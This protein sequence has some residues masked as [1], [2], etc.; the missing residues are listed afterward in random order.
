MAGDHKV[1]KISIAK[2]MDDIR[3]KELTFPKY[4]TQIINLANQNAQGTRPKI[5]GQMSELI[6][7]CPYNDYV[8]WGEWYVDTMPNAVDEATSRIMGMIENLRKAINEIDEDMVHSWVVDLLITKT[9]VGLKVQ[10]GILQEVAKLRNETYR[11]ANPEEEAKGID[12]FIGDVPISIKP[13]SYKSKDMLGETIDVKI[14][15]YD[16]T[17]D[18]IIVDISELRSE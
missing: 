16:K 9:F 4:A 1:I 14:L 17:K 3:G 18:S 6:I 7:Q 8:A 5:V 13:S 11:L 10:Q 12:G 2:M 15:F